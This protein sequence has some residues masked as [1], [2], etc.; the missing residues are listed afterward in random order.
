MKFEES[1]RPIGVEDL[2]EA[3]TEMIRQEEK[4][5]KEIGSWKAEVPKEKVPIAKVQKSETGSSSTI[6]ESKERSC[7]TNEEEEKK[8]FQDLARGLE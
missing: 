6:E 8:A 3:K 1:D 2:F 7:E 5:P 4:T